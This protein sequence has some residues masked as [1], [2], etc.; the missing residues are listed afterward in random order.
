VIGGPPRIGWVIRYEYDWGEPGSAG[1]GASVKERP[2]VV[3]L[4]IRRSDAVTVVRVAPVTHLAPGDPVRA[5]ELPAETK[6]RLGLDGERS[7]IVLDHA[8]EFIWPGPDL[9]PVPR[10]TPVTIYYGALP[11]ALFA[12]V[13]SSLL[14]LLRAGRVGA[15]LRND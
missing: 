13:K 5:V 2:A 10:R 8:N 4:S 15:K 14:D 9:R 12:K 11:P 3:V 7:W 1:S 6:A